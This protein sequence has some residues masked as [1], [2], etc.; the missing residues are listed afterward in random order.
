MSASLMQSFKVSLSW[1][2]KDFTD[3]WLYN[4][5]LKITERRGFKGKY[6]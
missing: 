4:F 3:S 5:V 1:K 6:T 2:P